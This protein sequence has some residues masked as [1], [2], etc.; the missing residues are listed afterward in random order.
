MSYRRWLVAAVV[1]FVLSIAGRLA[2]AYL[3]PYGDDFID[4]HVYVDGG[5]HLTDGRLYNFAYRSTTPRLSLPFTYPPFAGI[6][7]YP[8]HLMPFWLVGLLWQA[9][10]V[11]S[12]FGCIVIALK[13]VGRYTAA[14]AMAATAIAMWTEPIRDLFLWGQIGVLL[15]LL[16]LWAVHSNRWWLS[17]LLVGLAA[18]VKL[19]PA[20]T[21]L[22]FLGEKRWGAAAFSAVTFFA[23][24]LV[25][26]PFV[27]WDTI[28]RYFTKTIVDTR[29][30]GSMG[31]VANQSWRGALSRIAGFDVDSW[32]YIAIGLTAVLA[33]F[34]WRAVT[35]AGPDR[36]LLGAVLV[37]QLFGLVA[38]P[39]SWTHHWVWVVPLVIWLCVGPASTWAGARVMAALWIV[40]TYPGVPMLLGLAQPRPWMISRP[41]YLAWPAT[42]WVVMT[43][44][45]LVWIV[46]AARRR[47]V[48]TVNQC[49]ATSRDRSAP[50]AEPPP[51]NESL[52]PQPT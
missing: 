41:W 9:G 27:G 48:T 10:I 37:V 29:R 30:I 49:S 38:V 46:V 52:R 51:N 5:S 14:G 19:T 36:D 17:G 33:F 32:S 34:A 21:G 31:D 39:V 2:V 7:F 40:V 8:L 26:W 42:I 18:G 24:V 12:L 1:L 45:T 11:A 3:T 50:S 47:R 4:L 44:A 43:L 6:L 13:L 28:S 20:V 15:M 25:A 35:S 22:Y 23:T 16:A